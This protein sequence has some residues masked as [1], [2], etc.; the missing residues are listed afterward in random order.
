MKT[1]SPIPF[2]NIPTKWLTIYNPDH[3]INKKITSSFSNVHSTFQKRFGKDEKSSACPSS[4][5]Y[6]Y[7]Q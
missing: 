6:G 7:S 1:E 3:F 2:N 5:T 4:N